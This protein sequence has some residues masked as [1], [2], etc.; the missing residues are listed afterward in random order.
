MI[1]KNEIL[2]R[3]LISWAIQKG[4]NPDDFDNMRMEELFEYLFG[5]YD[6]EENKK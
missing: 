2:A 1:Y 3:N 6:K 4:I 5:L